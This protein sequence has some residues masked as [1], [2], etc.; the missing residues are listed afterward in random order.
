MKKIISAFAFILTIMNVSLASNPRK[1]QIA[2]TQSNNLN[3]KEYL[4]INIYEEAG[5]A[6]EYITVTRMDALGI[7]FPETLI[8]QLV[9][10]KYGSI[11]ELLVVYNAK[12]SGSLLMN[13]PEGYRKLN[14]LQ[15]YYFKKEGNKT[16]ATSMKCTHIVR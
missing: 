14:Y 6:S 11:E 8:D 5:R 1:L 2:C 9:D 3:S 13:Y 10:D 12:E 7:N 16:R 15:A 4:M